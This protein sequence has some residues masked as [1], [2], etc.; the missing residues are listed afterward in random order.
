MP[1]SGELV[2]FVMLQQMQ[3][4]CS[5]RQA[6]N[7]S[8]LK[9]RKM[10]RK[11]SLERWKVGKDGVCA[12]CVSVAWFADKRPSRSPTPPLMQG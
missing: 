1:K 2:P 4:D 3:G 9:E 5:C 8:R 12:E 7:L 6:R 10:K 11:S